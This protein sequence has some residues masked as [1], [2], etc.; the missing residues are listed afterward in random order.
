LD[1][2]EAAKAL[3]DDTPKIALGAANLNLNLFWTLWW[4]VWLVLV[5]VLTSD[6]FHHGWEDQ[7]PK[8]KAIAMITMCRM[9]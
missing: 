4:Y 1:E 7:D 2:D 8:F 5:V 3:R 9:Y 6:A